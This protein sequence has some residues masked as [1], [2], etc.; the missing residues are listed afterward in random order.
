MQELANITIKGFRSIAA[1]E[2]LALGAINVLIGS[3]GSGKSNF[4]KR[5]LVPA[6]HP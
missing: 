3:N 5:V 4:V 1:I 6:S 2:N